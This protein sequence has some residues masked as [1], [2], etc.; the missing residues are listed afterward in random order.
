MHLQGTEK[1]ALDEIRDALSS[2]LD[3]REAMRAAYPLLIRVVPADY[4]ALGVSLPSAPAAFDWIVSAA[5]S[6]FFDAYPEMAEHDFVLRSVLGA[7]GRVLRDSEMVSRAELEASVMYGRA[8]DLGTPL[9]HVMSALLHVGNEWSSGVSFFRSERRPFSERDRRVLQ[10]LVPALRNTVR[11]CHVHAESTRKVATLEALLKEVSGT[12]SAPPAW[13]ERLTPREYEVV[14]RVVRGWDNRLVAEEIGCAEW[15]VRTHLKSVYPKLGVE[16][17]AQLIVRA[18]RDVA[19]RSVPLRVQ[20]S[21]PVKQR[22][23]R[24]KT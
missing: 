16:T 14:D 21:E 8:R 6:R 20:E 2:S 15:T 22:N 19:A 7:P 3:V 24:A 12:P 23:L 10:G 9:E 5:P 13:R 1:K 4:V 11:N 17:R 18:I